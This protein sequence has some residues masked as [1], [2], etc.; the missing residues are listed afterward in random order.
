MSYITC[1]WE[2]SLWCYSQGNLSTHS[3]APS[4][5]SPPSFFLTGKRTSCSFSSRPLIWQSDSSRAAAQGS[6]INISQSK[7]G[8]FFVG[9]SSPVVKKRGR[10]FTCNPQLFTVIIMK[11]YDWLR[12]PRLGNL[13]KSGRNYIP[14]EWKLCGEECSA[15]LLLDFT[16]GPWTNKCDFFYV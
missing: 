12:G 1:A 10:L 4:L 2:G 9:L 6:L 13:V 14:V 8:Y 11:N 5:F 15:S 3:Y 16:G 7:L